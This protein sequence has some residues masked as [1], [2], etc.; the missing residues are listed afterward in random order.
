MVKG[1]H[2]FNDQATQDPLE[3]LWERWTKTGAGVSRMEN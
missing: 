2:K 3:Q 1:S